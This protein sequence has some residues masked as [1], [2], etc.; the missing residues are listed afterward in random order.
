MTFLGRTEISRV[1]S[2]HRYLVSRSALQSLKPRELSK[3][4]LTFMRVGVRM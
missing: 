2:L 1:N 4:I 3:S